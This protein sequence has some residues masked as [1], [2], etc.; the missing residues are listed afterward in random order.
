MGENS[1]VSPPFNLGQREIIWVGDKA[2]AKK[3]QP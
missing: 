1:D 3:R 2:F